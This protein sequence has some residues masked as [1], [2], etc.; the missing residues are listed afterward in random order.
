MSGQR[1]DV[2][3]TETLVSTDETDEFVA[4]NTG[5]FEDS[6]PDDG[7]QAGRVATAGEDSNFHVSILALLREAITRITSNS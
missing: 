7:I 1:H 6:G 2:G 5:A 4:V 3:F